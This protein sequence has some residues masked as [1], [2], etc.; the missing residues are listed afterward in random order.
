VTLVSAAATFCDPLLA[1]DDEF[2]RRQHALFF[3]LSIF[4]TAMLPSSRRDE[5]KARDAGAGTTQK[6]ALMCRVMSIHI[7]KY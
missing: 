3:L 2:S 7:G 6:P 1:V 5:A 4:Q